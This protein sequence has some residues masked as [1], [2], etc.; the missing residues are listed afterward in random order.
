MIEESAQFAEQCLW[1]TSLISKK[2]HLPVLHKLL[3]KAGAVAVKT[4]DMAQGQKAS[5]FIA[6]SF[7]GE[8][9]RRL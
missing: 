1:F 9:Q 2:D 5:R 8:K 7:I 6:W 3:K 4:I